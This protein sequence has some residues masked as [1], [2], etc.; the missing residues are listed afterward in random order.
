ML[1]RIA[2]ASRDPTQHGGG[3]TKG[4]LPEFKQEEAEIAEVP[5]QYFSSAISASSCSKTGSSCSA[6]NLVDPPG[7]ASH[8]RSMKPAPLAVGT[9][10]FNLLAVLPAIA[11]VQITEST[12]KLRV[13]INGQL[14]TEY[15]FRDVPR[16]CYFPVTGPGGAAM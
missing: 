15:L 10:V 6:G 4:N 7:P 8:S 2:D 16:P 12:N 9:L 1:F 11:D 3:A 14:F 5:N 13:E